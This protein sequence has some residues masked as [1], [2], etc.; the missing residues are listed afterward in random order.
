MK[1]QRERK[2][3]GMEIEISL[4]ASFE[5]V[6]YYQD[7]I[8]DMEYVAEKPIKLPEFAKEKR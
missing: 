3:H 6:Q 7:K 2:T 4:Y 8:L 1:K 5:N